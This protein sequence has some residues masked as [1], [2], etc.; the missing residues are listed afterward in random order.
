MVGIAKSGES[1][2][3]PIN[4]RTPAPQDQPIARR[5]KGKTVDN[6]KEARSVG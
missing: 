6:K 4:S 3:H 1:G 5:E 2:R